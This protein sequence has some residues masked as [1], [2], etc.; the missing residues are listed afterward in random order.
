M[1]WLVIKFLHYCRN[2]NQVIC[3]LTKIDN[4][5]SKKKKH[6]KILYNTHFDFSSLLNPLVPDVHYKV[7]RT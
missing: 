1:H 4:T 5:E 2:I 6:F 3:K 7:I